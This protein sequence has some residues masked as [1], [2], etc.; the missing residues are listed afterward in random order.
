MQRAC[1]RYHIVLKLMTVGPSPRACPQ[2]AP[3][4]NTEPLYC[5]VS[6]EHDGSSRNNQ[7]GA[8]GNL[9][10]WEKPWWKPRKHSPFQGRE[11]I[12]HKN[13]KRE[14]SWCRRLSRS[15]GAGRLY[16][17][18]LG[19]SHWFDCCPWVNPQKGMLYSIIMSQCMNFFINLMN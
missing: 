13:W 1:F 6:P 3:I 4:S 15:A 11:G 8:Q 9:G 10:G 17:F 5:S 19:A 7:C 14:E 12:K 16:L 2:Y 18:P